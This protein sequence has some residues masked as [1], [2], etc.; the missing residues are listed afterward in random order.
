MKTD[1][2]FYR[3]FQEMPE[4]V[5]EL[6]GW[7][8]PAG[9]NYKLHAEEVKQ[10]SFRLDGLLLPQTA[11]LTA[12]VVFL[13]VQFQTDTNLY[14]RCFSELCL[15]LYRQQC[16]RP[17]RLLVIFPHRAIEEPPPVCFEPFLQL[18]WVQRVYLEDLTKQPAVT[19][20]R[21]LL[22]LIM[23]E[24][25]TAVGR[26]R[27]ILTTPIAAANTAEAHALLE[28]VETILVYKLPQLKREEI[29]AMLHLP[30]IDL[31]QTRFYLDAVD[32]GR[33]EGRVEGQ[34]QG[35][36]K[37]AV[38]MILRQLRRRLGPLDT[39]QETQIQS[40]SVSELE[41]LGEALLDFH[42]MAELTAWLQQP[43]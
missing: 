15:W 36:K 8:R 24:P 35:Q 38:T 19:P 18:L 39:A 12:P 27:T 14:G 11:E 22:Q 29:Q 21:Q 10:T 17:W 30:D 5:F 3:L 33:A 16:Q 28:L 4:L 20:G 2:L 42:N 23:A 32:E 13:E 26:A 25:A 40:L 37:E 6:A 9:V 7:P 1:S 34:A 41:E 31:K 43:R